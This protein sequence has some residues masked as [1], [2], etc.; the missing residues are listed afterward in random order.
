MAELVYKDCKLYID[1]YD[2]SGFHNTLNLNYT[3]DIR[4]KTAF[5]DSTRSKLAGLKMI[6][7]THSGWWESDGSSAPDDVLFSNVSLANKTMTVCPTD[8]AAG[9]LAYFLQSTQ[10]EYS[11]GGNIGDLM[12]FN[13]AASGEGDLIRGVILDTGSKSSSGNSSGIQQGAVLATQYVYAAMHVISVSGT[14]PTLDVKVQSDDNAGF[15]SA[16][17]RITFTQA[18]ATTSEWSTPKAGPITDD[19]WRINY[20]IGGT[21]TPT[22]NF[23][24]VI[25][26][27]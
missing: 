18:T 20:T 23:I 21:D 1:K 24:V 11:P 8:G 3:A 14:N 12:A 5:G 9:S 22:F 27:L 17:D 19:Y 6:D 26:I 25:G 16:T 15:T 4:D 2:L 13:F 10:G 7:A